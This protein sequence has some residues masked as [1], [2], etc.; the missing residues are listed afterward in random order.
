MLNY[1]YIFLKQFTHTINDIHNKVRL[2]RFFKKIAFFRLS[3]LTIKSKN[4]K[5]FK[6]YLGFETNKLFY[7]M[8]LD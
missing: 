7:F 5:S 3:V 8:S 1:K 2:L 6:S 4:C